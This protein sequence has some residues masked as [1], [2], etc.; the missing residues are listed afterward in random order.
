MIIC[1]NPARHH[2]ILFAVQ[3]FLVPTV[4][5]YEENG[6]STLQWSVLNISYAVYIRHIQIEPNR[7][8][9]LIILHI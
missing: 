8:T 6:Y 2:S 9:G 1:F 3:T 7:I 5:L 4:I